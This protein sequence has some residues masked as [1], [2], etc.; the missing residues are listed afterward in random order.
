MY[1]KYIAKKKKK[2]EI[3]KFMKDTRETEKD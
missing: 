3:Y 2:K 1:K